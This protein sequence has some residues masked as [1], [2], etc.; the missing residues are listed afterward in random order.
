M[1]NSINAVIFDFGNVLA[2]VDRPKIC[3]AF[4]AHS[5]FPTDEIHRRIFGTDIEHDSETGKYDSQEHFRRIK[6]RIEGNHGWSY[7][8]FQR[9]YEQGLTVDPYGVECLEMAAA[10]KRVFVLSNISYL[11]AL[12]LFNTDFRAALTVTKI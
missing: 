2:L 11:H 6:E 8:E 7:Q 5:P 3:T 9:E 10:R 4:S 12:Y 1:E